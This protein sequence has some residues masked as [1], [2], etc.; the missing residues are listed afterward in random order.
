MVPL[1]FRVEHALSRPLQQS[2]TS[3]S[4]WTLQSLGVPAIAEGNAILLDDSRMEI[5]QACSGLRIFVGIVALA[6][7]YVMVVRRPWWE[8]TLLLAHSV[9]VALVANAT[10]IVVTGLLNRWI[11]GEAGHKFNHDAAGWVMIPYA[12]DPAGGG[13]LVHRQTDA[14]CGGGQRWRCRTSHF[15]P[16]LSDENRGTASLTKGKIP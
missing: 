5:E 9:P 15:S 10:R 1:P 2:A 11:S 14:D 4:C 6:F 7:A 13:A 16:G 12:S 8:K 3:I